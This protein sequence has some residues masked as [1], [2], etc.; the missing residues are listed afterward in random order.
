MKVFLPLLK[1]SNSFLDELEKEF[2]GD[3]IYDYYEN[4]DQHEIDIINIHWP[5]SVFINNNYDYEKFKQW[6]TEIRKKIPVVYTRHNSVP[7]R[8]VNQDSKEFN[9]FMN[10]NCDAVHH[11]G[12]FSLSEHKSLYPDYDGLHKVIPHPYYTAL[13]NDTDFAQARY[14]LGIQKDKKVILVFGT[15]RNDAERH[16]ILDFFDSLQLKNSVLLVPN[17]GYFQANKIL[18]II[19]LGT[20]YSKL[21]TFFY[22]RKNRILGSTYIAEDDIQ[23]YFKAC[24]ILFIPRV[25]AL[26]SGVLSL[27]LTFNTKIVAPE[28]GNITEFVKND[29]IIYRKDNLGQLR[30]KIID[31]ILLNK[32]TEP[33]DHEKESFHPKKISSSLRDF[34][35][36]VIENH[37]KSIERLS[38]SKSE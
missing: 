25:K 8:I 12:K 5:E 28:A 27:G 23:Y 6:L 19:R 9:D 29:N 13:K 15:I 20:V 31:L 18:N 1:S 14:K 32:P 37:R 38:I 10:V 2:Y 24:D 16:F 35:S 11:F 30:Q 17:F 36:I 21:K 22:K 26:N 34:F 3:F 33:D 4:I 7:H